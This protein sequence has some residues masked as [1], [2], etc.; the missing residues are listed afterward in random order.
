MADASDPRPSRA[1]LVYIFLLFF[2]PT[3]ASIVLMQLG[4]RPAGTVNHGE[5]VQPVEEIARLPLSDADGKPVGDAPFRG[6]WSVLVS[7]DAE[8]GD[9]CL[10]T[11]SQVGH[12]HVALNKDMDRLRV[13]LVLPPEVEAPDLPERVMVLRAPP[14]QLAAWA[15]GAGGDGKLG[16][17]I[18][19]YQGL[20]MMVYP[21]PLDA[22][23]MLKDIRRLLRLSEED[24]ERRQ[25]TE[26]AAQ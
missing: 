21:T 18:V 22:S 10:Q 4:W 24:V 11:L 1:K 26:E 6:H 23:G 25:A 16:V 9:P 2:L 5:L 15:A 12:V 7:S 13:G 8:C 14:A 20:R 3:V 17:H 19:D